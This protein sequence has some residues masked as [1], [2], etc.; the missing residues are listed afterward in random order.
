MVAG[1]PRVIHNPFLE[2]PPRV[3]VAK[4]TPRGVTA[5]GAGFE[6]H[7]PGQAS[8][9]RNVPAAVPSLDRSS[10]PSCRVLAAKMAYRPKWAN[11]FGAELCSSNDGLMSL[12]RY[13]WAPPGGA[14]SKARSGSRT[15]RRTVTLRSD[16][17]LDSLDSS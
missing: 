17:T 12:T 10:L 11:R 13:G 6:E 14:Q 2:S 7:S 15:S 9:R 4:K 16:G 5:M 8:A 3:A 1:V